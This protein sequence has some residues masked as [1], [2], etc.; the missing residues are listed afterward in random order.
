[1]PHESHTFHTGI[2]V[3]TPH[4]YGFLVR[5]RSSLGVKDIAVRAGVIEGT[6]R[7]EWLI[8]LMNL[9]HK[10]RTFYS[11][12]K[13]AQA[14]LTPIVPGELEVVDSLPESDRGEKGFGSSG[15]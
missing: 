10:P 1:M 7:G 5:D 2:K 14:I 3:A 9:S 6:Y 15:R 4:N 8:H 12:D 13:I 11:G